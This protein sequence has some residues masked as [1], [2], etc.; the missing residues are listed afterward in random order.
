VPQKSGSANESKK[1]Q[2]RTCADGELQGAFGLAA[3]ALGLGPNASIAT[4]AD[5]LTLATTSP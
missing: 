2:L 5:A 3:S 4:I 1:W